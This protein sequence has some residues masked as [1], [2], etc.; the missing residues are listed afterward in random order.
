MRRSPAVVGDMD[1]LSYG[2]IRKLH[3]RQ[4]SQGRYAI[5]WPDKNE[6]GDNDIREPLT[7]LDRAT[8]R[9]NR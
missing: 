8:Q 4:R 1:R 7:V 2:G 9:S 6:N 3:N 5:N